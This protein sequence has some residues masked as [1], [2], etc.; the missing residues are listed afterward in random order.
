MTNAIN[1]I[2]TLTELRTR[3]NEILKLT[4]KYGASNVR[5]FGSV[6]RGQASLGSDVDILITFPA[7]SSI[8]EVVGLWLDLQDLLGYEVSLITDDTPD[9]HFMGN[10]LEDA[11]A[12]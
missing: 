4:A 7:K 10:I 2:P 9:D 8:F 3:R 11:V 12:L 1:N 6:A 5:I